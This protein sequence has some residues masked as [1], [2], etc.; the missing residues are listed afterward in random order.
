MNTIPSSVA[1]RWIAAGLL[2]AAVVFQA[3][4]LIVA[5]GAAGA[6]TVAYVRG[7][8][9]A[10]LGN[11]YGN[12]VSASER[13]VDKLQFRKISTT[14]DALKTVIVARTAGDKRVEI[15]VTKLTDNLSKVRIRVGV[16]GDEA[17]SMTV[18]EKIR[19]GL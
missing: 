15:Q 16:F 2:G 19:D 11:P 13:A 8:L 18:L 14:G 3:G 5:A 4:C 10:S 12:V 9:E 7:E 1:R 17:I 6:G